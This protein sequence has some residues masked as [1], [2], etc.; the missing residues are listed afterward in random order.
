[1][2]SV[3][4]IY[5]QYT[6]CKPIEPYVIA[7]THMGGQPDV[8]AC[9]KISVNPIYLQYTWCKPIENYVIASAHMV[10]EPDMGACVKI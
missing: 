8:G 6:W 2:I 1:M 4:P 7:W 3:N 5:L 10:G 9:V